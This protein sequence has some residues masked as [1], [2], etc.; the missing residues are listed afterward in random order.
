MISPNSTYRVCDGTNS[1]TISKKAYNEG[2]VI[3]TCETCKNHHLIADNLNWFT[4]VKGKNIEEI[5]AA[6]G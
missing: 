3:V 5:L 2:V 1:Y 6:K 4:D